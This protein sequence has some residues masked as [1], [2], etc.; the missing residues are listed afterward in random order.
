MRRATV[1]AAGE[2]WSAASETGAAAPKH[3]V[4][5]SSGREVEVEESIIDFRSD[6]GPPSTDNTRFKIYIAMQSSII[7]ACNARQDLD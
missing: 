4:A 5:F 3:L 6:G 1:A 2:V 7:F